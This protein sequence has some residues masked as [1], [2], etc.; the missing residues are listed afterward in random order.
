M[1]QRNLQLVAAL[2]AAIAIAASTAITTRAQRSATE[3]YAI[4][5]TRIV[6]S[7]GPT[8]ERGTVVIRNG[9]IQSVGA[10]VAAPADARIIDGTGLT[11]YPGLIDAYSSLGIP[12][13]QPSPRTDAGGAPARGAQLA[14][15][16]TT[17]FASPN[18][19]QPPGLQP[20]VLASDQIRPGGDQIEASR[21]AG[22]T[23][24]LSAPREG[25]FM[26]QSALI[27][28]ADDTPQQMIVKSPVALHIGF[29]PLRTGGYPNS[30][31]GVFA[32]L[33]QM[34]LDAQRYGQASQIYE[35]SSRAL[36][37]PQQDK[38][39]QALQPVIAG[40]MPVVMYAN[41]EREIIRALDLAQ[42]F[43][44]RAIIAG[45]EESWKVT[46]RLHAQN[47]PVLLSLNLPK[48]ITAQLP[49]ADPET[50]NVL[51]ARV[52]APKTA[53]RLAAARVR[54]AFE[55][56]AMANM[57]DFLSN[58]G[59]TV[60]GGLS[61]D[62]A[63]RAVTTNAAQILGLDDRL[64]TIEPGKIANLTIMRGDLLDKNSRVAYVFIDG[65]QVDLK[66]VTATA[67]NINLTGTWALNV[68]LGEG[69]IS[70]TL[71]LQQDGDNLRGAIQGALGSN[72]IANAS[73]GSNGE[74]R[75]TAPVTLPGQSN[76]TTEA[77]FVGTVSGSEMRGTVQIV[78]RTPGTFSGSKPK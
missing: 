55:S 32:A 28:L 6:T 3:I 22:F 53:G 29:T 5:N 69:D 20:E 17:A 2:L 51:R 77:N 33:R 62:E 31:M 18:S 64:G 50:L 16:Q 1:R 42:E 15:I 60:E 65:Q 26:G 56:G 66:P 61:R 30:L 43:K 38:S 72:Q 59:K 11:V 35:K 54:F 63:I 19:T 75:F 40:E 71:T 47:V 46:D 4:T 76:Q 34:L 57:D 78:G 25:I 70:V 45:G 41:S 24:A 44:L 14:Q 48:R 74:I 39:L 68:N 37:R 58:L 67:P 7:N 23:S 49:E 8:I 13:P 21:N 73:I 10:N 27:N 12:Q 9:L 36:R 52:E